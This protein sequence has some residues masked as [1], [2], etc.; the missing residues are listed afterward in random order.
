MAVLL[1]DRPPRS[2]ASS[3]PSSALTPHTTRSR[4]TN[5]GGMLSVRMTSAYGPVDVDDRCRARRAVK[6]AREREL[7]GRST[8]RTARCT[9]SNTCCGSSPWS[10]RR[11]PASTIARAPCRA[12]R[13]ASIA[14]RHGDQALEL[15][16]RPP[17][18]EAEVEERDGAVG[19][20]PVVAGVRIA[21]EHAVAVHRALG[22]AEQH[23]GGAL[24]RASVGAVASNSAQPMPSTH[25]LVST[26]SGR[27]LGHDLGDAD[28]RVAARSARRTPSGIAASRR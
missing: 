7:V 14:S 6:L 10:G 3:W 24:L 4:I 16:R 26:R 15:A 19:V 28:E 21:V 13:C 8:A 2:V 12:R 20:E 22:E 17:L 9:Y 27:Q 18:H 11:K 1:Q 5:D 25:S 23:L